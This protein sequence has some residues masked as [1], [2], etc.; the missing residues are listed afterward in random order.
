MVKLLVVAMLCAFG[1]SVFALGTAS[2]R[3]EGDA[4]A[5]GSEDRRADCALDCHAVFDDGEPEKP[6]CLA[7]CY[8]AGAGVAGAPEPPR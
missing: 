6:A 4:P 3:L 5:A 8:S 2:I 7:V 1:G